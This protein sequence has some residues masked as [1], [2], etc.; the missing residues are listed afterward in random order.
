[1]PLEDL[2]EDDPVEEASEAEAED[3]R[4]HR[5][6]LPGVAPRDAAQESLTPSQSA[7]A[8]ERECTPIFS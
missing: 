2:V 3:E 4:G 7:I 6:G 5:A 8:S 1:M